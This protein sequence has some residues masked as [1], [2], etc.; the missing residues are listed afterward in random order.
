MQRSTY[1]HG[2]Q[3][4]RESA[5][6]VD[7]RTVSPCLIRTVTVT[8]T[9]WTWPSY[10]TISLSPRPALPGFNAAGFLS[11]AVFLRLTL[12]HVKACGAAK[13]N[14]KNLVDRVRTM[15]V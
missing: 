12:C 5:S 7:A 4:E 10:N 11:P 1:S 14:W 6:I 9:S 2:A 15:S 8:L 3:N 13:N